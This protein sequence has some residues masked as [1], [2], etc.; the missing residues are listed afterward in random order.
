MRLTDK[1][2]LF[3][4]DW[5]NTLVSTPL[6]LNLTRYSK[7]RYWNVAR[8]AERAES[9]KKRVS[10]SS[11]VRIEG[12][13]EEGKLFSAL[14]DVYLKVQRTKLKPHAVEVLERLR[15]KGKKAAVFSDGRSVRV[16]KEIH[17]LGLSRY[18]DF[19]S[20]ADSFG[21]YKPDPSGLLYIIDLLKANK[22]RSVYVG[23]M[24]IDVITA[25]LAGVD[26]C[27]ISDG[28]SSFESLKKEKPTYLLRN[29]SALMKSL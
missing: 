6:L 13:E 9:A 14:Y 20:G 4:F 18:F 26:S 21:K 3:I 10:S 15:S 11:K 2:S 1:Y 5:D 8:A 12:F 28:L 16:L 27:A 19:V 17:Y 24:N 23:D 7:S 29:L 25:R 22:K